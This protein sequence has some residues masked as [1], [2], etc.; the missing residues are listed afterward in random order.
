MSSRKLWH[1]MVVMVAVTLSVLSLSACVSMPTRIAYIG[2]QDR[3]PQLD[4]DQ[5]RIFIFTGYYPFSRRMPGIKLD[6]QNISGL[7]HNGFLFIDR[8][9]GPHKLE[10]SIVFTNQKL[11]LNLK[12]GQS[13]FVEINFIP[14]LP[15]SIQTV[16]LD[17]QS[18]PSSI[19][20][21]GY[22]GDW[23]EPSNDS[24]PPTAKSK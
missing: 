17:P 19:S 13:K 21:R 5:G 15:A 11:N 18:G 23:E 1:P 22:V 14:G 2:M 3:L 20:M 9:V 8:P 24:T 6:G 10:V 7:S 12:P 4:E 16:V